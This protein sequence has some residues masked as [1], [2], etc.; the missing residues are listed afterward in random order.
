MP[1]PWLQV[2]SNGTRCRQHQSTQMA[3]VPVSGRNDRASVSRVAPTEEILGALAALLARCG[4]VSLPA[5]R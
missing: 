1:S 3:W 2:G 4:H 5:D